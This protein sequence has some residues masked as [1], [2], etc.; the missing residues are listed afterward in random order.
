M[1]SFPKSLSLSQLATIQT[2]VLHH[3]THHVKTPQSMRPAVV[4]ATRVF[5]I[6]FARQPVTRSKTQTLLYAR[7][8]C[9]DHTWRSS[10]CPLFCIN[11]DPPNLNNLAGGQGI[12]KCP[13]TDLDMYY[14][15][16]YNMGN[17]NCSAQQQVLTFKGMSQPYIGILA[18]DPI[19]DL[20]VHSQA[21]LPL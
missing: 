21:H 14:C 2:E 16:D 10:A 19:A 15:I 7:E 5:Q 6:R 13:N 17:A 9:T 18:G 4:R 20:V 1:A 12:E 8:S 3:R 11:P